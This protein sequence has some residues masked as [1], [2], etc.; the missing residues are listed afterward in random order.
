M[1]HLIKILAISIIFCSSTLMSQND[2]NKLLY[3]LGQEELRIHAANDTGPLYLLNQ[4][5]IGEFTQIKNRNL[6]DVYQSEVCKSKSTSLSL[7]Q[8][9]LKHKDE[10]FLP[11]NLESHEKE[12]QDQNIK[13]LIDHAPGIFLDH[14]SQIQ[15]TMPTANCLEKHIPEIVKIRDDFKYLQT[16]LTSFQI[17]ES[18]DRYNIIIDKLQDLENFK[19]LCEKEL[20]KTKS[21]RP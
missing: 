6:K 4:R 2:T 17:L 9:L 20:T 14:L 1:H 19:R 15:G 7:L 12:L 21:I 11:I 3:C 10:I 5:M 16:I 13:T 8:L 18:E